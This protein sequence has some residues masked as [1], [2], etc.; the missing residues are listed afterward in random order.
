M[1]AMAD[2]IKCP[3]KSARSSTAVPRKNSAKIW[4]RASKRQSM[5]GLTQVFAHR[6]RACAG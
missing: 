4:N 6:S 2:V 1:V 5:V 3:I